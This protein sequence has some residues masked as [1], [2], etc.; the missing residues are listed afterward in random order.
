MIETVRQPLLAVLMSVLVVSCGGGGGSGPTT[1]MPEPPGTTTPEPPADPSPIPG[2]GEAFEGETELEA[3]LSTATLSGK[4]VVVDPT[5]DPDDRH[6]D[7]HYNQVAKVMTDIGVASADISGY[8]D[9]GAIPGDASTYRHT[10]LF[11]TANRNPTLPP[12]EDLKVVVLPIAAGFAQHGVSDA[13]GQHNVVFVASAGNNTASIPGRDRYVPNH[14]VWTGRDAQSGWPSGYSSF[15]ETIN[16]LKT[17]KALVVT[18]ANADGNG[19]VVPV[20]SVVRCGDAKDGC[21][22]ALLPQDGIG[23][24][25]TSYAAP[26]VGSAAYYLFQLWD[27]AEDVVGTLKSCA[28]DVGAPGI[29]EEFGVGALN[30]DCSAVADRETRTARQSMHV[31][32]RSPAL[33]AAVS[34]SDGSAQMSLLGFTRNGGMRT[35]SGFVT[36]KVFVSHGHYRGLGFTTPLGD[37]EIT[38]VVGSGVAPLGVASTLASVTETP[39]FE[40]GARKALFSEGNGRLFLAGSYGETDDEIDSTVARLGLRYEWTN[41]PSS[42]S[43]YGGAVRATG[44]V[45]IPGHA[46]ASRGRV[47]VRHDAPEV[48]GWY[49]LRF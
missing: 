30:L 1:A 24:R 43:L 26:V 45:G 32:T 41:G 46:Q 9:I 39:F 17:G 12:L 48:M 35:I 21:I 22:T 42:L 16:S 25:G 23:E 5:Y 38:G 36:P 29:D 27:D 40:V 49:A 2:I 34:V 14:P 44:R 4:V 47:T 18:W 13:I 11:T 6:P 37:G 8:D 20:S 15:D 10:P 7:N 19:H 31:Q 28:L 3:K 33:D